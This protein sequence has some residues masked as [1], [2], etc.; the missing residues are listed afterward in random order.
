MK[1]ILALLLLFGIVS[2][3]NSKN[4]IVYLACHQNTDSI[5]IPLFVML[6][7]I[8]QDVFVKYG[9]DFLEV[10]EIIEDRYSN[11]SFED[12]MILFNYEFRAKERNTEVNEISYMQ[13]WN[14]SIDRYLLILSIEGTRLSLKEVDGEFNITS[15]QN[16]ED[17][18][19]CNKIKQKE[20]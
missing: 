9:N 3:S 16:F 5:D 12:S 7:S 15:S 20:I 19:Y 18:L 13:K 6:D 17:N 14:V 1:K 2:C 4:D 8:N 10:W 11:I